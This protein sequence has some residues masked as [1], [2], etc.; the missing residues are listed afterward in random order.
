MSESQQGF[1]SLRFL[2]RNPDLDD[3]EQWERE[4]AK[5]DLDLDIRKNDLPSRPVLPEN[6]NSKKV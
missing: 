3:G 1:D 5:A 2:Y 4:L 6:E